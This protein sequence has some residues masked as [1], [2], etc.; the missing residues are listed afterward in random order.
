MKGAITSLVVLG[1]ALVV[2]LATP[3]GLSSGQTWVDVKSSLAGRVL[4]DH[5]VKE[6]DQVDSGQPL[7]YVRTALTGTVSVA[8]RAPHGGSVRE[9]LVKPGQQLERGAV[10]VRLQPK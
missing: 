2:T 6:G 7:V 8:A 1:F 9:V 10:V 4:A 5:L 3:P